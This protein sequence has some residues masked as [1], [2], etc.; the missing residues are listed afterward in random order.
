MSLQN[1]KGRYSFADLFAGPGGLSLGFK[2]SRFF[3][4][5]VA[6][7]S[8]PKAAETYRSNLGVKVIEAE[9]GKVESEE[10]ANSLLRLAN[11]GGHKTIHTI[12]GGPPCRPF[13]TANKGGTRWKEAREQNNV[14]DSDIGHPDWLCFSKIVYALQPRVVVAEN[15]LGFKNHDDVFSKF[16]DKLESFGYATSSCELNARCFG[17]PQ[18]RKRIFIVGVKDFAGDKCSL[19]PVNPKEGSAGIVSVKDAISDLPE[20]SNDASGSQLSKYRRVRPTRYQSLMRNECKVLYDHLAHSVHPVMAE[21]FKYIPSG[22]NLRKTWVEGKIPETSMQSQ[23]VRGNVRKGFSENTLKNMH[24]NIYRRLR[25][26][27]AACTITNVRKTVLI[28][29]QQNRLIS[30]REAARLQSFPDWFRFS[31]SISQQYQQIADAV[32]P[33]LARAIAIHL[34]ELLMCL[35]KPIVVQQKS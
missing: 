35:P 13:T 15:V 32:P 9:I 21:R 26:D 17:I 27:D 3:E 23:Y 5:I 8:N 6:V 4:P 25:W 16:V 30:V 18:N 33:L 12:V 29:P 7:E 24:S 20:L 31:G 11:E 19:L 34:A 22:Y 10:V 14:G 28:H 1:S 2:M